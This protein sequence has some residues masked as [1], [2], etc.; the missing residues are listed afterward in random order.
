M[1]QTPKK[2]SKPPDTGVLQWEWTEPRLQ[3]ATYVAEGKI[4]DTEICAR[5]GI[6]ESML[7]LW[8]RHPQFREMVQSILEEYKE[9]I[10]AKSIA[11]LER[12]VDSY[13]E[14]FEATNI[15]LQERG[16]GAGAQRGA[17][18]GSRTGYIVEDF[19]GKDADV[20]VYTFD[21]GL[22]RARIAIRE[23]IQEE[24]GQKITKQEITGKGGGPLTVLIAPEDADL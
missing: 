4:T 23:A 17:R 24:L 15:I 3:A 10:R 9:R 19:K 8:K 7:D 16:D 11:I 12:R 13:L 22:L 6:G 21:A 20:P 5:V 14:D 18:G 2:G 1:A